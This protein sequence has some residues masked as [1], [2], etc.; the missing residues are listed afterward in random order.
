MNK[1]EPVSKQPIKN[2]IKNNGKSINKP[3][4]EKKMSKKRINF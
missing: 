1:G 3:S 4:K 2:I